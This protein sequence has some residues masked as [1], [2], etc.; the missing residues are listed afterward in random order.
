MAK[1]R[2]C[3]GTGEKFIL[4]R[5][6][7]FNMKLPILAQAMR[8]VCCYHCEGTGKTHEIDTGNAGSLPRTI[9]SGTR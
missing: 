7:P 9:K 2:D 1:C 6:N 4:P 3:D 5:G 8:K